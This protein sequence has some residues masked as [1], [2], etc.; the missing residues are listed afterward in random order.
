MTEDTNDSIFVWNAP[1]IEKPEFR[2][3]YDELGKTNREKSCVTIPISMVL[4]L[5]CAT[6]F[7]VYGLILTA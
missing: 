6:S 4:V 7:V 2:L 5:V 1:S 3:Y